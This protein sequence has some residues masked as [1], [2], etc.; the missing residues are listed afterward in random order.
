MTP[1]Q[2]TAPQ[3][4]DSEITTSQARAALDKMVDLERRTSGQGGNPQL[5]HTSEGN[6]FQVPFSL[7]Y[8]QPDVEQWTPAQPQSNLVGLSTP[9]QFLAPRTR[10]LMRRIE[11]TEAGMSPFGFPPDTGGFFRGIGLAAGIEP[12]SNFQPVWD[13]S[14]WRVKGGTVTYPRLN[15]DAETWHIVS[16]AVEDERLSLSKGWIAVVLEVTPDTWRHPEFPSSGYTI[17]TKGLLATDD[18]SNAQPSRTVATSGVNGHGD[19]EAV[20]SWST[21]RFM[22]P[23]AFV[24][25]PGADGNAAPRVSQLRTHISFMSPQWEGGLPDLI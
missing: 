7:P 3:Q 11:D 20:T 24:A 13:G 23:V 9:P 2:I 5:V 8:Q 19:Y 14:Q 16:L 18:L 4:W 17:E 6:L 21:G 10:A 22:I 12:A 15:E 25:A 1:L